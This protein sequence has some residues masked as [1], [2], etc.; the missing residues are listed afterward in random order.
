MA[1]T[2]RDTLKGNFAKGQIPTEAH[3]TNLI[4]SAFSLSPDDDQ[5][6]GLTLLASPTGTEHFLLQQSDGE[7]VRTPWSSLPTGS[8]SGESNLMETIGTTPDIDLYAGKDSVT[9][10]LYGIELT[11]A[12]MSVS[13]NGT[14]SNYEISGTPNATQ[15]GLGNVTNH[16]QMKATDND[17]TNYTE[18][19]APGSTS[20]VIVEDSNASYAK[21][22]VDL[23][24][25]GFAVSNP[26]NETEGSSFSIAN[27]DDGKIKLVS[28]PTTI[29]LPNGLTTGLQCVIVKTDSANE[30]TYTATTTLNSAGTKQTNQYKAVYLYHAG[31]NVWYAFGDLST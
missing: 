29:T 13:L 30:I 6:N 20:R 3:F 2:T 23:D 12:W 24:N 17:F 19:T 9:F 11:E 18:E 25:L 7:F 4:D 16:L 5:I 1:I 28:G 26:S 15:V 22:R 10:Q 27:D 14:S 31:S 21:R 8:G